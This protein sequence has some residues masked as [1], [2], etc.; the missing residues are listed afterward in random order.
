MNNV[1]LHRRFG[2]AFSRVACFAAALVFVAGTARAQLMPNLGATRAGT[3]AFTFLKINNS[4]RAAALAGAHLAIDGDGYSA[5]T[6]PAAMSDLEY[7]SLTFSNTF[8]IA[9]INHSFFSYSRPFGNVG[10]FALHGTALTT[11]DMERRTELQPEGTGEYFSATNVAVGLSYAKN[12]TDRFSYGL[13]AKYV[14]ETLDRFTAHAA[15]ID[16]GFLYRLDFKEIKFAVALHN[17]GFNSTLNGDTDVSSPAGD[18]EIELESFSLPAVFGIGISAV[19]VR[20]EDGYLLASVQLNHPDDNS[21]NLR[22]GVEYG[23]RNFLFARAGYKVN[24]ED[25]PYPTFG[26]GFK[27]NAGRHPVYID[28][29]ADPMRYLGWRHRIGLNIRFNNDKRGEAVRA[30]EKTSDGVE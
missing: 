26:A 14:N 10:T 1:L 5:F 23:Y 3:S 7:S 11:G 15:A 9:D 21:A 2:R 19:P 28:Y 16:L 24:V 27:F 12:L 13:T 8:W 20:N 30:P 4:P 6:N 18:R 22:M 17:F 29:S 25:N